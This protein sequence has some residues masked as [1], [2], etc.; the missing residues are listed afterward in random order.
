MFH[1]GDNQDFISLG[2]KLA[3]LDDGMHS[4]P[5]TSYIGKHKA[6]TIIV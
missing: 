6:E 1:L 3:E 4:M 2:A 5:T